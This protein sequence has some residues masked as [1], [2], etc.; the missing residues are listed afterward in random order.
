MAPAPAR[1]CELA[2]EVLIGDNP[3]PLAIDVGEAAQTKARQAVPVLGRGEE[4]FHPHLAL[5]GSKLLA[6]WRRLGR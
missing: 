1:R 3:L 2:L 6:Q 4:G 5:A